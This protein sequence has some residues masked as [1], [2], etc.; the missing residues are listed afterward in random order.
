[1]AFIPD[2]NRISALNARSPSTLAA[3]AVYQGTGEDVSIYGRVGV[4]IVSDNA[5][6]GI[7]T[8]ETSHDNIT[9]SGVDRT[10]SD[11]RSGEPHM[12]NIVEQYFRIKYTNGTADAINLSIQVQYSVNIDI[13]LGHQLDQTLLNETEAIITRSILVGQDSKGVY[14]NVTATSQGRLEIDT[15]GDERVLVDIL[16]TL[17]QAVT[18][19]EIISGHDMVDIPVDSLNA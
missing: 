11:T 9:Y 15:D 4:S 3:L 6:D 1:M 8:M 13:L 16:K 10:I 12:W 17:T 18:L 14:N 5:T 7:L 19:L 2:T